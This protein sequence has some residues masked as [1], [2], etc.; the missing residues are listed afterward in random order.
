M[1]LVA[2]AACG[3][4]GVRPERRPPLPGDLPDEAA[5]LAEVDRT[6]GVRDCFVPLRD[7]PLVPA[8]AHHE[9]A[10][11]EVV[12]GLDTGRAQV[13]YPVNLLN[14]HEIVEHTLDGLELLACW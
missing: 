12:L 11:D 1:A 14:H 7:P 10:P 9:V 6:R 8:D 2:L 5:F 4:G 3:Q 13:A